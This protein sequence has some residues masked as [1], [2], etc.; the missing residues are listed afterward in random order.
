M[1]RLALC[2]WLMLLCVSCAFAQAP[3]LELYYID[4][5]GSCEGSAS[6]GCGDCTVERALYV[7]YQAL[8]GELDDERSIALHNVRKRPVEFAAMEER[9]SALGIESYALPLAVI[10]DAVFPADGLWDDAIAA[11]LRDP[12]QPRDEYQV[13][14]EKTPEKRLE[15]QQYV[16]YFYSQ[17]CEDCKKVSQWMERALPDGVTVLR[18]DIASQTGM[19]LEK[20]A[21]QYYGIEEEDWLV[22]FVAYG[23][24]WLIGRQSI[25][26]ALPSRLEEFPDAHTPTEAEL[27]ALLQP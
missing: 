12:S 8:L 6:L 20:A 14:L 16:L 11:Y 26:F 24:N 2:V 17:Y 15:N 5:C 25:C 10:G 19:E 18:Y 13:I 23:D 22:P 9:L 7:R 3:S 21:R 4:P 1:K 27:Y